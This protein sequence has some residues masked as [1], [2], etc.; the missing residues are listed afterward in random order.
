MIEETENMKQETEELHDENISLI[1]ILNSVTENIYPVFED[2][3]TV[4]LVFK[5]NADNVSLL[6]DLTGWTDTIPFNKIDQQLFY[7]RLKLEPD[8]R[9]QYQLVVDG[10]TISD[11]LNR[12]KSLHGLGELSELAM[13][14]YKRHPYLDEYLYGREGSFEGLI[15]H[16]LPSGV[17]PYEH[18]VYVSLP[19]GYSDK[20]KYPVIYF[21]DGPDYI[22]YGLAPNSI[23]KLISEKRIN[24]CIAVFVTPPNLH[25]P[26]SPNRSTEYGLN[27]DYVSFFCDELVPFT[28]KNYSTLSLN[29]SRVIAGDS[30]AGLISAYI[31]FSRHDVFLNV[32]SQSGYFSFSNDKLIKLFYE[33][34]I[35]PI[36]LLIDIGTY[37]EKVGA[38]FLPPSELN[39]TNAN[40]R[41]K[42]ILEKKGYS[43]VYKEYH[44]GHTWGNWRRHLIDAL[45]YFFGKEELSE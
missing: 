14:E 16:L 44:E 42:N 40:R 22:K 37:E 45:I 18:E 7:L 19:A 39:F 2:N 13:P 9:I 35:K 21:H 11:P 34:E 36:N 8:A 38:D 5:G 43:F 10:N 17:L 3:S 12:Y 33:S 41:M 30:Y 23:S 29:K 32:Y 27:D 28:D 20:Y 26:K 24:P 4:I 6:S 1:K 31:G 25:Q 15:K